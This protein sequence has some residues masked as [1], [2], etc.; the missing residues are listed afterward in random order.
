MSENY[1]HLV[2]LSSVVKIY[3]SK[4]DFLRKAPYQAVVSVTYSAED[5]VTLLAAK[6]AMSDATI[7]AVAEE[8]MATGVT[9]V[10]L[11]RAPG[12]VFPFGKL[13]GE[14]DGL[15]RYEIDLSSGLMASR[16]HRN[17]SEH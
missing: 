2:P 10:Y 16:E 5:T 3:K 7:M 14:K 11:D 1:A 9:K 4:E 12:H 17:T 13:I 6:G 8:L 15:S